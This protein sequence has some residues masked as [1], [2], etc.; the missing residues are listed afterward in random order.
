MHGLLVTKKLVKCFSLTKGLRWK[1][2]HFAFLYRQYTNFLYC[3]N[4]A[5]IDIQFPN[6]INVYW[7]IYSLKVK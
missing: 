6:H 5:V 1:T 7:Y 2:L 3:V 4:K